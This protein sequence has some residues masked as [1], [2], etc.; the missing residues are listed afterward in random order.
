MGPHPRRDEGRKDGVAETE[1]AV[2]RTH[3]RAARRRTRAAPAALTT[4][5]KLTTLITLATLGAV[6]LPAAPARLSAQ[7]PDSAQPIS[8]AEAVR[9]AQRNAPAMVQTRGQERVS[10]AGVT[11]AYA[12]FLPTVSVSMGGV[13]QFSGD[14]AR[15]RFNPQTGA[16]E[17]I[18]AEPWTYSNGLSLSVD[19]FDGGRR[20]Y[21]IG[22][23]R[24]NVGA[25]EAAEVAQRF[26]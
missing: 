13:R 21:D 18:P 10:R 5:T 7:A 11:S 19:L 26:A 25:S 15:T 22:T 2:R 6:A 4:L 16:T 20:L 14:G 12:A 8:L 1:G 23:A 9:L 17:V 3:Q 24:A